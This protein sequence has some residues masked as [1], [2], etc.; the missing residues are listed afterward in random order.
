[1]ADFQAL[2]DHSQFQEFR[3]LI[4]DVLA[5]MKPTIQPF[6][7]LPKEMKV[8]FKD[9]PEMYQRYVQQRVRYI[10][11]RERERKQF[12]QWCTK[13]VIEQSKEIYPD[14]DHVQLVTEIVS[15]LTQ[16]FMNRYESITDF[17]LEINF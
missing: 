6:V 1:M 17:S 2:Y 9:D 14:E 16:L 10:N 13:E 4:D 7:G 11:E 12:M 5:T 3:H 15:G 8:Q